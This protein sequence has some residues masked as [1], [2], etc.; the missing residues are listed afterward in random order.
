MLRFFVVDKPVG[1]TSHD[2]VAV[3]KGIY[4]EK[5]G[6]T[7]TL[8]PFATGTLP[9]AVGSATRVIS[10]LDEQKKSYEAVLQL[11][12][13]TD[14]ADKDGEQIEVMSKP[15][16]KLLEVQDL[17][18]EF[19][20]ERQQKVPLYS[21]VKVNGRRLYDYA[22]AGHKVLVVETGGRQNFM[23]WLMTVGNGGEGGRFFPKKGSFLP[24][25]A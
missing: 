5:V 21:A 8:D 24:E 19:I 23:T 14:T 7:G 17:L 11:G 20:G 12:I 15:S 4:K 13:K 3:F 2:V 6:H 25:A 10:F 1:W 9:V 22:R 18:R 16:M